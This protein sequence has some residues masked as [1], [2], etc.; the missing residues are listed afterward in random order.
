MARIRDLGINV[1]PGTMRPLEIGPGAAFDMAGERPV[2]CILVSACQACVCEEPSNLGETSCDPSGAD[3]CRPQHSR[4]EGPGCPGAS[5]KP[6]PP[7]R[8][9]AFSGDAIAQL[10][11]Q[12]RAQL[13]NKTVH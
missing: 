10:R 7:H 13:E 8:A 1:I 4:D 11:Q 12:L 9:G 6:N 2:P 5:G 3:P